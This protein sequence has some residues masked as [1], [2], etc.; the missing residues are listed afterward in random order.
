MITYHFFKTYL[1]H[2]REIL[3]AF[4]FYI[5]VSDMQL[6][7]ATMLE[8]RVCCDEAAWGVLRTDFLTQ[9]DGQR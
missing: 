1:K 5:R 4:L 9:S 2:F 7:G 3:A 8:V 6:S